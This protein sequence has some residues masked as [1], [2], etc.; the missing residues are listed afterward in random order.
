MNRADFSPTLRLAALAALLWT[1]L[2]FQIAPAQGSHARADSSPEQTARELT[3]QPE[4]ELQTGITLSR[5]GH[6][7]EA[8]PHFLA[9]RGHISDEYAAEFNLALC[10]VGVSEF[11]KAISILAELR[12][13]KHENASVEN[14][15]AQA[16]E[17]N[18][19]S[20]EAFG[21]FQKAAALTPKDEKLYLRVEAAFMEKQ[22]Y[23]QGLRVVEA[24]IRNLPDSARLHYELGYG[25]W[26]LEE[27]A[28]A[29]PEFER[30]TAIAPHSTIGYLAAAQESFMLGDLTQATNIA[31]AGISEGFADYQLLCLL[32]DALIHNGA[33]P[34]KAEFAEAKQALEKSIAERANYAS[35]QI[36][37]GRVL[38]QEDHIDSAIDHLELGHRLAPQNP[39]PCL[40]LATAYRKRGKLDQAQAMLAI[41]DKLN[42]EQARKRRQALDENH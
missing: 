2:S 22:D 25:L 30:A 24:G 13:G 14:L 9:A 40:L 36:A 38:L 27:P 28:I 12:N 3:A 42:Q 35:S 19:Q 26:Q 10:Y 29:K 17:G 5:G 16:Y 41:V 34:G 7:S 15:L 1:S 4:V 33:S 20:N 21:A 31:R 32:G 37:L 6:F 18:D 8:I 39:T 11:P 23:A